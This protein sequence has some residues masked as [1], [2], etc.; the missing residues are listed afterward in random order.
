MNIDEMQGRELDALVAEKVMGF[1][2]PLNLRHS[3]NWGGGPP[4]IVGDKTLNIP[5]YSSDIAAA[6]EVVKKMG[7]L[8]YTC[9]AEWKGSDRVYAGSAEVSFVKCIY[10]VGHAVGEMPESICRAALKALSVQ[11]ESCNLGVRE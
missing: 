9:H 1:I 4:I 8:G 11:D 3:V 5:R 6:F 10:T 2:I 7:E